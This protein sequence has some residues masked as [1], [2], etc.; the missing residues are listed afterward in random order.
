MLLRKTSVFTGRE[1]EMDIPCQPEDIVRWQRSNRP[2]QE[3]LPG[4][5]LE[6]RE[7]LL[8]GS[9]PQEWDDLF[10]EKERWEAAHKE[11][12]A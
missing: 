6:Q 7:F 10:N 9:T 8:S 12:R 3:M 5:T 2:I 1:A 11:A 4:L